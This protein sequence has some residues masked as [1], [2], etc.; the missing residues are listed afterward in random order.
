MSLK[1]P[2]DDESD[3]RGRLD[4]IPN[5][6]IIKIAPALNEPDYR[7]WIIII[8]EKQA[9]IASFDITTTIN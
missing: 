9:G 1:Y 4:L 5:H 3:H 2:R 8:I 7:N 6:P